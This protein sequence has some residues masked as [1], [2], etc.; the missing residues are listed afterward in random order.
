MKLVVVSHKECWV[1]PASPSGYGTIGGFPFQMKTISELFDQ[2]TLVV[3]VMDRPPESGS[4]PL[5]GHN[6]SVHPVE[7]PAG[8]NLK[9]KIALLPWLPGNVSVLW[10]AIR[11][12]DAVHTPIP[13]AIGTIGAVLAFAHQKPLFVRY[14]QNW[15]M[16]KTV[17][18]R[19]WKWAF[20]RFAGGKN[21][22]VATGGSSEPP[23]NRNA[24]IHWIFATSLTVEE[25][26]AVR[27]VRHRPPRG[28]ARLIIVCRQEVGK[29]TEVVI[30]S[31]PLIMRD[32]P[33]LTLDVVGDGAAL[34]DFRR[35]SLTL[36]VGD[37]VRFHGSVDHEKVIRLLRKADL[38]CLPT[39]SEG[40]P[41]SVL[42]A[43]ACGLPVI[44]TRVSVLPQLIGNGCG[45][46]VDEATPEAI[47][48]AVHESFSDADQY[49]EMS[50]KAVETASQYSLEH[51][52]ETINGM[53][54]S[55]WGALRTNRPCWMLRN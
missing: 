47:A 1:D 2:T 38:F 34:S 19:A 21:V 24:N 5:T 29:G 46:L 48:R 28:R 45:I 39:R 40:F 41:K 12:A 17:T 10:R 37:N 4:I 16:P 13:G 3:P 23:S 18:D 20:E 9:R 50:A 27:K 15:F 36:G 22:M 55:A 25:L 54:E 26:A 42:E 7:M 8:A 49:H 11:A 43:L 32:F 33:S 6:L 14:C 52:G 31:L 53:L 51:W 44:T 30:E 35:L